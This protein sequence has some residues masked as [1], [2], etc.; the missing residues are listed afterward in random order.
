[1]RQAVFRKIQVCTPT[2]V[3]I[4]RFFKRRNMGK[5]REVRGS[6]S[7]LQTQ[8]TGNCGECLGG[9]RGYHITVQV[10]YQRF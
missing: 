10:F 9:K 1:M 7:S 4:N 3:L 5:M 2:L 6:G 8:K